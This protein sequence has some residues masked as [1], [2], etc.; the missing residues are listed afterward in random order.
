ML[1]SR[2]LLCLDAVLLF[3]SGYP[4][5][6]AKRIV[7]IQHQPILAVDL[8]AMSVNL[9]IED[10]TKFLSSC[11]ENRLKHPGAILHRIDAALGASGVSS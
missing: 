10:R 1:C 7:R 2:S 8:E 4:L 6:D 9:V 3:E 5:A 11:I